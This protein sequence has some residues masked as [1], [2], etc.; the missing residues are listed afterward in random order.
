KE[1]KK[2]ILHKLNQ[3]LAFEEFL[4]K[5]YIGHKRFSLEGG[6][7]MIPMMHF[8][9]NDA[10]EDR[11]EKIFM[12]MAHRGRLN[13]LVNIMHIPYQKV[14]SDFEGNVDPASIQGSGDVKYHI[15]AEGT[16]KTK[17]GHTIDIEL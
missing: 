10:G 7:S 5:K 13:T 6:D 3:A 15:G 17:N 16:H 8:L 2:D 12:G 14:F 4:G 1:E 9:L 11:V